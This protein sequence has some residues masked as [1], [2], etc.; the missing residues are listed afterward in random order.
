MVKPIPIPDNRPFEQ[1][2]QRVAPQGQLKR[3]WRLTGGVSAQ[4]IAFEVED[5]TGRIRKMIV[6][7]HGEA[8]RHRNPHIADDEFKLLNLLHAAG[9]AV[10]RPYYL[11]AL[12]EI[13]AKPA[14]VLEY[15]EGR[16]EFEPANLTPFICQLAACLTKIHRTDLTNFDVSFLP[17]QDP[18]FG[19]RP[20]T[21][22]ESL[23]EGRIRDTVEAVWP[24]PRLN[25]AALLHGDFWPGNV[26]FRAGRLVA[27]I[28]W[29]DAHV[30]D[31]LAD[32]A[33]SRLE[34][35]W[36]FGREAMQTFT[37]RYQAGMPTLDFT[38]LPVWDLCAALRPASKLSE[39]GLTAL[40]EKKMWDRH[41]WFVKQAFEMLGVL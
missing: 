1:L 41:N 23:A 24:L 40:T 26:L 25:A 2:V 28:D 3:I 7:L 18:R 6:R 8:D 9:V 4:M 22:D 27:V 34:I 29:E 31:P 16:P 20:E 13:F 37:V 10:P 17:K 30:G 39:W 38:H 35:L 12:G 5:S 19:K 32:V 11:D 36:A 14:V 15:I 33:N 21:L